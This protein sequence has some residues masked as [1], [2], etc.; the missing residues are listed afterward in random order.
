MKGSKNLLFV[1]KEKQ[2]KLYYSGAWAVAAPTPMA[3]T[4][5]NFLLRGRLSLFFKKEDFLT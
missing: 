2:K 5:K 4:H 1:N 3:Q